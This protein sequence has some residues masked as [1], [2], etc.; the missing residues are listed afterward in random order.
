MCNPPSFPFQEGREGLV[1]ELYVSC[2]EKV[3]PFG[4][5]CCIIIAGYFYTKIFSL[6]NLKLE[7]SKALIPEYEQP[8]KLLKEMISSVD[9]KGVPAQ[10]SFGAR[11]GYYCT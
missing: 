3:A 7:T 9:G 8:T 5:Y 10:T 4:I 2:L 11:W 1:H 6:S